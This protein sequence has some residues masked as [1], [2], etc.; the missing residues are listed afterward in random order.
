MHGARRRSSATLRLG[1]DGVG[2]PG[3]A[4]GL[5]GLVGIEDGEYNSAEQSRDQ[6]RNDRRCLPG[7]EAGGRHSPKGYGTGRGGGGRTGN[8]PSPTPGPPRIR[9]PSRSLKRRPP[10]ECP[11]AIQPHG[12]TRAPVR[13]GRCAPVDLRPEPVGH[14]SVR[15]TDAVNG[16]LRL[17]SCLGNTV[18]DTK[19]LVRAGAPAVH[20]CRPSRVRGR[21]RALS[22]SGS[23]PRRRISCEA[24]AIRSGCVLRTWLVEHPRSLRRVVLG[25]GPVFEAAPERPAAAPGH[26][27]LLNRSGPPTVPWITAGRASGR[28]RCDVHRDPPWLACRSHR[29]APTAVLVGDRVDRTRDR[30]WRSR[31]GS[32]PQ[33]PRAAG[34]GRAVESPVA[35]HPRSPGSATGKT[36]GGPHLQHPSGPQFPLRL[37]VVPGDQG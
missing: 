12:G 20:L 15:K 33:G 37:H 3:P 24:T 13:P 17:G 29:Q 30:R 31:N 7:A 2:A 4:A 19:S 34:K 8:V 18:T 25:A 9:S 5:G 23:E 21:R 11:Y 16:K 10:D 27:K 14:R 1:D 36:F 26:G 35:S 28:G 32:S 6:H 22:G